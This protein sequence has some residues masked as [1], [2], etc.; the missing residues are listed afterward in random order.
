MAKILS[1]VSDGC[2]ILWFSFFWG[3]R[4]IFS[5]SFI[6]VLVFVLD[7]VLGFVF[8]GVGLSRIFTLLE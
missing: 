4:V 6:F 5:L 2:F 3:F 8:R 7:F 1:R